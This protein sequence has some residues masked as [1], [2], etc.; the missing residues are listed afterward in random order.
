MAFD[1]DG[2]RIR[3]TS[4]AVAFKGTSMLGSWQTP[5]ILV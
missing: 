3:I 1:G 2:I 5:V 4:K